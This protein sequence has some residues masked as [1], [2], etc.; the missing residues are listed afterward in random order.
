MT[1]R[2]LFSRF[3]AILGAALVFTFLFATPLA[4]RH[5][6]AFAQDGQE[7]FDT[8]TATRTERILRSFGD[9]TFEEVDA[10]IYRINLD[11]TKII[12]KKNDKT[13]LLYCSWRGKQVSFSRINE[14]NKTKRFAK[15]YIDNDGDPV[16][17]SDYELTGGVTEQNVKEWMKTYVLFLKQFKTYIDA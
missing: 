15:A 7:V 10:N 17:E 14:W 2:H 6:A 3:R 4:S 11:G 13:L 5:H 8:M 12:L 16:L 9:V 1:S